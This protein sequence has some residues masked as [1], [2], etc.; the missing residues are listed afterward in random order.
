LSRRGA[1]EETQRKE[2][3]NTDVKMVL[4]QHEKGEGLFRSYKG[5]GV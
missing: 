3:E 5:K 4:A 2:L 1:E